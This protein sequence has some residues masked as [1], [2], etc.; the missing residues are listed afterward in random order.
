MAS[1]T[2]VNA[3]NT[4]I[5]G[6]E[7]DKFVD[8]PNSTTAVQTANVGSDLATETLFVTNVAD[9]ALRTQ[10][11]TGITQLTAAGQ[12]AGQDVSLCTYYGYT[13]TVASINTNVIVGLQG[14]IDGSNWSELTLKNTAV[15][16]LSISSNRCTIT[17][18]GTYLIWSE[19]P[20]SLVRF[21]FIS[22]SGGTAATLDCDF[23]GKKL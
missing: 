1:K 17:A 11:V 9:G 16:G 7:Y 4:L 2:W 3:S 15:T 8:G 20:V 5:G 23:F 22:E 6:R 19:A 14:T 12:T 21:N 10:K 13:V 18:N